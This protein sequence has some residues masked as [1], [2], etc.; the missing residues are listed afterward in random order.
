MLPTRFFSLPRELRDCIY[1]YFLHTP[2]DPPAAL[3]DAGLEECRWNKSDLNIFHALDPRPHAHA[4]PLLHCNRQIRSEVHQSLSHAKTSQDLPC[5]LDCMLYPHNM[6]STWTLCPCWPQNM[7]HLEI[8]FRLYRDL[9]R[10]PYYSIIYPIFRLL[11]LLFNHGPQLGYSRSF[12][13]ADFHLETLT[14]EIAYLDPVYDEDI[15]DRDRQNL[16][17][18]D[19]IVDVIISCSPVTRQIARFVLRA[20]SFEKVMEISGVATHPRDIKSW[21]LGL[22]WSKE[23]SLPL[24][25]WLNK[26]DYWAQAFTLSEN[27]PLP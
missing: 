13:T 1:E 20:G 27:P 8:K 3:Q 24:S 12:R 25:T 17:Y 9:H 23:I 4:F 2:S 18:I 7:R 26:A 10:L 5:K 14:I 6:F 21:G 22:R 15:E 16:A 11:N 19:K